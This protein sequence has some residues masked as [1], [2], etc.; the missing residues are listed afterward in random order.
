MCILE[1]KD[2]ISHIKSIYDIIE[3]SCNELEAKDLKSIK[4]SIIHREADS[5]NKIDA[6]LDDFYTVLR[7]KCHGL[8]RK[9][10]NDFSSKTNFLENYDQFKNMTSQMRG[11]KSVISNDLIG[12]LKEYLHFENNPKVT[13]I[14]VDPNFTQRFDQIFHECVQEKESFDSGEEG[15]PKVVTV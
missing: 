7:N 4:N 1:H 15:Q 11:K 8:K 10:L 9:M 14:H 6:L 13:S 3:K 12:V 2:H 5:F